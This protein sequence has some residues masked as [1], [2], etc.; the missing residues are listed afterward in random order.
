LDLALATLLRLAADGLWFAD[1]F[2][3]APPAGEL[4]G[5]VLREINALA[6][7]EEGG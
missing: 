2:G 7:G 5:R 4:R 1:L 3:L 6:R